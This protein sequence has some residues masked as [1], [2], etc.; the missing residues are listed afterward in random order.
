LGLNFQEIL[1]G[2]GVET[3]NDLLDF[4]SIWL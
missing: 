2:V 3:K 1:G 4:G